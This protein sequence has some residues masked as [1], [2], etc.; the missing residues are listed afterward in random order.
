MKTSS[1]ITFTPATLNAID[2]SGGVSWDDQK[3]E[4]TVSNWNVN[5]LFSADIPVITFYGG[6]GISSSKTS[7]SMI[8][9]YPTPDNYDIGQNKP[10]VDQN[11]Y[12]KNGEFPKVSIG[13]KD[14]TLTKPRLNAGFKLKLA[15]IHINFDYTYANY[16]IATAGL[17]ISFR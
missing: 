14:G 10:V 3:M 5:L 6:V 8:G 12:I 16:S 7:L 13:G 4:L 11:G 1:N 2:N 15:I 17:G 9:N